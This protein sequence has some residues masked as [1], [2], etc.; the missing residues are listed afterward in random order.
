MLTN[1]ATWFSRPALLAGLAVVPLLALMFAWAWWRRRRALAALGTPY[2]VRRQI[3]L[4]PGLRRW[5]SFLVLNGVFLL[6]IAAAGP[7]WGREPVS[8][9]AGGADLAIVLDVSRSMTAEQPSRLE[10]ALRLLRG[11]AASLE[12]R[13]GRRIALIVFAAEPR[14]LFPL[15]QDYDH[16]LHRLKQIAE[17]DLEP[18]GSPP[19]SRSGTRFGAAL[20]LAVDSRDKGS[21]AGHAVLLLSDGDDPAADDEEW[22][23]GVQAASAASIRVFTVGV[24][25][26]DKEHTIP[27]GAG[28]LR[29]KDKIVHTRL[30]EPLLQEIARRTGGAYL[31]A[32]NHGIALGPLLDNLLAQPLSS[33]TDDGESLPVYQQRYGWFL[34]LGLVFLGLSLLLSEGP[35][36]RAVTTAKRLAPAVAAGVAVVLVSAAPLPDSDPLVRQGNAA[37]ADG[38][39]EAALRLFEQAERGADDPGLVAFNKGAVL[40]RLQRFAES[41]ACFR[42]TLDDD[43]AP[44]DRRA[45]AQYDLGTAL[46]KQSDGKSALLLRRAVSAFRACL[47]MPDLDADL[48]ANVRHNL[49]L[50]QL[51]WLKARADNPD[52]PDGLGEEHPQDRP[53]NA[54]GSRP[55]KDGKPDGGKGKPEQGPEGGAEGPGAAQAGDKKRVKAGPLLVLPDSDQVVPLPPAEADAHL[56]QIINRIIQER[57]SHWQRLAAPSV[58]TRDW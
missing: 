52:Q 9:R 3:L 28:V 35:A 4:R 51:L 44:A 50:A 40:F 13:G 54:D 38:D 16:F 14:L 45:R 2:A 15:T 46:V 49:E 6:V 25:D 30:N 41:A 7:Q 8:T 57:R 43:Q 55:D 39:F 24:G 47:G 29:Y 10:R 1:L 32:H 21:G 42:Q 17:S 34:V 19:G 56:D 26:P 33:A 48:R 37:F 18:L 53:P 11:L 20:R 5:R 36:R 22:Q 23:T 12:E 58:D 31:P 27:D